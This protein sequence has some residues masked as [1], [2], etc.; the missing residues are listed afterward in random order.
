MRM[1]AIVI[2]L[3][4]LLAGSGN[5]F[6][7]NQ[8]VVSPQ[9]PE[10]FITYAQS[11]KLANPGILMI[12]S[13]SQVDLYNQNGDSAHVPASVFKLVTTFTSLH[14]LNPDRTFTTALFASAKKN[15]V[16]LIGSRDPWLTSN[17]VSAQKNGQVYLPG[18]VLKGKNPA[19]R[20]LTI[21]HVG[22]FTKDLVNLKLYLRK[23][24]IS[25]TFK[26]VTS[27]TAQQRSTELIDSVQSL[28]VSEMVKFAILWSD[29]ELADRL[30]REAAR[31]ENL[32][33]D[34][35][36][37]QTVIE[38]TLKNF[39]ISSAQLHVVDGSGLDKA[40]KV[41]PRTIVE[42]L[43]EVRRNPSFKAI[44]EGLP[45]SGETGTLRKRFEAT[46]QSA[47]GLVHAKTGWINNVVSL[48]GY[49]TV[50][51]DEY[52][53][54]IIADGITPGFK[55]RNRA[56]ETIDALLGTIATPAVN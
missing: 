6:A 25:A 24:G 27:E 20:S 1:K 38:N 48:A 56:R 18:L 28:P 23:K 14:V 53:F 47:I 43:T 17:L 15:T 3:A 2:L 33:S 35:S 9:L 5:A 26:S 19:S 39:R 52:I 10:K 30:V 4:I 13:N 49:V 21:E 40:N 46:G 12:D 29:N 11:T 16:V 34:S 50:G 44:Y 36:G 42:I 55:Y 51:K 54:A 32:P 22:V 8:L 31:H 37:L 7:D 45:I 41:T